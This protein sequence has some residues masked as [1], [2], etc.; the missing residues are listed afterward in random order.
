[1]RICLIKFYHAKLPVLNW[2]IVK[3]ALQ[4]DKWQ[5]RIRPRHNWPIEIWGPKAEVMHLNPIIGTYMV[6]PE[7]NNCRVSIITIGSVTPTDGPRNVI[8]LPSNLMSGL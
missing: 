6:G 4:M 2:T 3:L 1:M 8:A 5:Q 7:W